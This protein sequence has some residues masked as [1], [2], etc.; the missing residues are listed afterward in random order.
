MYS[1]HIICLLCTTQL[2]N[3]CCAP[4]FSDARVCPKGECA[5]AIPDEGIERASDLR[6]AGN[7]L[8]VRC[9]NH[10]R[11]CQWVGEHEKLQEHLQICQNALVVCTDCKTETQRSDLAKHQQVCEHAS[12]TCGDCKQTCKRCELEAHTKQACPK[13]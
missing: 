5:K 1:F 13:R 9:I 10:V 2:L 4:L 7:K 12:V 8:E 3:V 6:N 11:A